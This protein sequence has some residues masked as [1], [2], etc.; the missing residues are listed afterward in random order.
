MT[1]RALYVPHGG[2]PL[3]LIGDPGHDDLVAYLKTIEAE[4]GRPKAIVVVSAHWEA[5]RPT[6]TAAAQPELYFDYYGFPP[7]TY[8]LSYPAPGSLA[9]AEKIHGILDAAGLEPELDHERGFDHGM[10]VPLMLMYPEA[11]IP[12]VQVSLIDGLDA[13]AHV[14]LGEALRPIT[15]DGDVLVL[16]SGM[17]FH[18]MAGFGNDEHDEQ[19][20]AFD[21]W[22]EA[23]CTSSTDEATRR[24]ELVG[25]ESA[26][27]ARYN[28]PR[29]E[30]LVP[31][32]VCYGIG[33]G[34]A[35][36]RF[37]GNV[38]GKL[39]AAYDWS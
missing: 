12:V 34:Q 14:A 20:L 30:H 36:R 4:I 38:L 15:D 11:T 18:N 22:L 1:P 24:A 25:W 37:T 21:E 10:F 23:V 35:S 5:P 27:A 3:P 33:G 31:L 17:S 9:L 7:E 39:T 29:E 26:P 16:G 8:E 19:N 6:I 28:H 32:H 13:Q 2:G